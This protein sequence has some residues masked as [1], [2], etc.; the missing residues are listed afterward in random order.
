MSSPGGRTLRKKTANPSRTVAKLR[1]ET[2]IKR[3]EYDEK[4]EK[5]RKMEIPSLHCIEILNEE[6]ELD[7]SLHPTHKESGGNRKRGKKTRK[8]KSKKRRRQ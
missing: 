2:A 8:M 7:K 1:M 3:R 5:C 4:K 6:R